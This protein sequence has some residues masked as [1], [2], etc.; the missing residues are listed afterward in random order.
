M[1][2]DDPYVAG[3]NQVKLRDFEVPLAGG[4]YLVDKAPDYEELFD[5]GSEVETWSTPDELLEKVKF[6]LKN[7]DKR[8]AIAEAGKK[9]AERCHTWEIRFNSLFSKLGIG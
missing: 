9:R 8:L 2:G 1:A 4:F 3:G 5:I 7:D 6:Y